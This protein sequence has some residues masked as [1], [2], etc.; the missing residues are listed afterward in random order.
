MSV[1]L[2]KLFTEF[3]IGKA[4]D[5]GTDVVIEG[6]A[7]KAVVDDV[8]DLMKFD[9]V[10][11]GRYKK[12]PILLYNHDRNLPIGRVI[13]IKVSEAGLWVKAVI[14]N[15]SDQ[16]VS[17]IRDLVKEGI[18]KTFSIGFEPKEENY[19]RAEGYN[20]ISKWR[21]NELSIVTLPANIDAEFA[22]A[23][24]L[25]EAKD[26]QEARAMVLK[27]LE[28]EKST[29]PKVTDT[30]E[31]QKEV[32]S[33]C[34]KEPC[35]CQ[36]PKEGEESGEGENTE[37]EEAKKK[38]AFQECVQSK[39][40]KLIE[41]GKPEEQAVAIAM[42]MCRE[43]GKCDIS[44]MSSEMFSLAMETAKGC[45][46]PKKEDGTEPEP[47]GEGEKGL[48]Q[49][50]PPQV[51]APVQAADPASEFGSPYIGLMQS[52]LA[53]MGKI[54]TQLETIAKLLEKEEQ[55]GENDNGSNPSL[56]PENGEASAKGLAKLAEIH[57]RVSAMVKDL[58]V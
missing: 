8:G 31:N 55:V 36:K 20:V 5:S 30:T 46:K 4:A 35:E 29:E 45:K 26:Y 33:E 2:K 56:P 27:A 57:G 40:P 11:L 23:K 25:G 21:L 38:A 34:G 42:S 19:N 10:D 15:S 14:S 32:C 16:I 9:N 18:L 37:D 24:S 12:N 48:K 3:T 47:T 54:S 58:G 41:E 7:N 50:Q 53:M 1:K 43:E 17:Y 44:Y 49:D 28:G 22:L 51:A 52:Q 13:E 6:W 39:I